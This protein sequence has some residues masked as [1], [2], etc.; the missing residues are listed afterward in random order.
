M[1]W[2]GGVFAC[3]SRRLPTPCRRR[4]RSRPE[5]DTSGFRNSRTTASRSSLDTSNV[6]HRTTATASRGAVS[7]VCSQSGCGC[8]QEPCRDASICRR[9]ARS[10]RTAPPRLTQAP[11]WPGLPPAPLASSSPA[12]E[13]GSTF[14]NPA[15]N[16]PQVRSCHE[17]RRA[18]RVYV[19]NL[20]CSSRPLAM[21]DRP[22][23]RRRS[24]VGWV[25][26]LVRSTW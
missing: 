16:V 4:Q 25:S 8:G 19:I 26:I 21:P 11:C 24:W 14:P 15:S 17:K 1:L 2:Q 5:R 18:P 13:D 20:R 9:S 12:C 7:V 23:A 6:L 22:R 3:R 10:S